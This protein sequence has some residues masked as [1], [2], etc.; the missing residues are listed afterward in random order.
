VWR[1]VEAGEGGL[2]IETLP[3]VDVAAL[4]VARARALEA[5]GQDGAPLRQQALKLDPLNRAPA[6]AARSWWKGRPGPQL[7]APITFALA[8]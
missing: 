1:F 3:H 4:L 2:D 7:D 8:P 6:R 5:A